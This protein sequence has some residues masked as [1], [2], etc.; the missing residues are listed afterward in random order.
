[1]KGSKAEL[2]RVG[3]TDAV[4]NCLTLLYQSGW[5]RRNLPSQSFADPSGVSNKCLKCNHC[6]KLV[7]SIDYHVKHVKGITTKYLVKRVIHTVLLLTNFLPHNLHLFS[8][9]I[10]NPTIWRKRGEKKS[11][12]NSAQTLWFCI[13][14]K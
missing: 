12:K 1:M 3:S 5:G 2:L 10:L 11:F 4:A 7:L 9:C 14:F 6:Y 13:V 8:C